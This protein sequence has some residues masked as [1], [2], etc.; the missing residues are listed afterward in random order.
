MKFMWMLV[1][2]ALVTLAS[3]QSLPRFQIRET[4]LTNNSYIL[5]G[6]INREYALKCVTDNVNCCNDS[7][8]GNWRDERGRAVH[9]GA[10]GATGLYVTRGQG[11]VSLNRRH[12]CT[13][14]TSGL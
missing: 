13:P 9:Q 2:T 1:L 5:F 8:V 11:V 7:D 12:G 3:S 10:D 4:N 6:N 14:E